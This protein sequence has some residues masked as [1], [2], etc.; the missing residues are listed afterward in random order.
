M[1]VIKFKSLDRFYKENQE[2]IDHVYQSIFDSGKHIDGD[3]CRA[4]EEKLKQLT[5]RKHAAFV[6]SGTSALLTAMLALDLKNKHISVPNYSYIASA[7]QAALQNTIKLVDVDNKG[8][9]IANNITTC[10]AV[11]PVSL[12]GNTPDYD[13]LP[14]NTIVIADCAQ[15]LG[16][17][18]KAKPD[19]SVGDIAVFSFS[20][21]KP[22][23]TS[24]TAGALVW[25]ND[26]ITDSV[27]LASRNGK[28]GRNTPVASLGIN[29]EPFEFQAG[30]ASIGLDCIHQWQQRREH[31]HQ[32][33]A[34]QFQELPISIIEPADYCTSNR[35]KF[36]LLSNK[37]DLLHDHLQSES[38]QSQ[39]HYTD[40]FADY[41]DKE[42]KNNY[43]GTEYLCNSAL[44]LP[45]HQWLTDAEVEYVAQSIKNFKFGSVC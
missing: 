6:S 27:L 36:V 26:N 45:N 43:P 20:G 41:F 10:D 39:K 32:Y 37:R 30:I 42:N 25:D 33:Y 13:K 4:A 1:A 5:G 9:L 22:V 38:V 31:I 40:N 16:S 24:G 17:T 14:K 35:H 44:S 11:I 21:N 23:P 12:Y 8:I 15:S 28:L 34:E 3:Y 18:Y 19:G 2:Q 29:A 7:N